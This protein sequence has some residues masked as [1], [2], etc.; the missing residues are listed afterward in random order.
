MSNVRAWL[1][2][3]LERITLIEDFTAEG[4]DAFLQSRK[5]QEAVIRCF[6]V[7]GE[8]IKRL[9]AADL[10]TFP[11]IPWQ[12]IA[13]FRDFL[14]HHYDRIDMN[15]VWKVVENDLAPLKDAAQTMLNALGSDEAEKTDSAPIDPSA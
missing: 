6:E 5:T 15:V 11:A 13:G 10:A 9:P 8:I 4:Q 2:D 3:V 1:E 12:E 7:I 14:I